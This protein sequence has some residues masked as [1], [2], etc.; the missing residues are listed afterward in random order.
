[1]TIDEVRKVLF[2]AATLRMPRFDDRDTTGMRIEKLETYLLKIAMKR[3]DLEEGRLHIQQALRNFQLQWE[4]LTGWEV[5][6]PA[7]ERARTQAAIRDAKRMV[8]QPLYDA[9][10]ECKWLIARLTEQINRL[11][12]MG[13]D[14]IASRTYTLLAGS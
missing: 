6:A 12:K 4:A 11:S 10:E 5:H 9:L 3:G 8:D 1:V 7:T 2:D 14:Q 13:D